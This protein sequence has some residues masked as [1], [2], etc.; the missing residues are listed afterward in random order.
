M[1]IKTWEIVAPGHVVTHV[2]AFTE[3]EAR[4]M[5]RF[6]LGLEKLPKDSIVR[7]DCVYTTEY[8]WDY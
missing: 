8:E 4:A 6:E 5:A 7:T 3:S 1:E 2:Q